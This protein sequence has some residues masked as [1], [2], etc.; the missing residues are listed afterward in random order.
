[1]LCITNNLIKHQSPVYTR[2]N[3]QAVLFQTI[4]FCL[5]RLFAHGLNVKEFHLTLSGKSGPG[6]NGNEGVLH[7]PQKPALTGTSPSDCLMSN[8]DTHW[9]ECLTPLQRCSRC[10]QL[11]PAR[12]T[13]YSKPHR[14][15][16]LLLEYFF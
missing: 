16:R 1:M 4:N 12:D 15:N 11:F 2:L 10:I 9:G 13:T 7:I 3:D 14:Q 6:N 8:Q 5:N